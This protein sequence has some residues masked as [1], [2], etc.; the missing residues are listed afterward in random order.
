MSTRNHGSSPTARW[1]AAGHA[2]P[3]RMEEQT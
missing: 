2:E 3:M 1:R